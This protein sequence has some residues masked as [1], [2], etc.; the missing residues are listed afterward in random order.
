MIIFQN[1]I[2][3]FTLD[4]DIMGESPMQKLMRQKTRQ[5]IYQ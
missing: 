2:F 3:Y 4:Q 1:L 5:T